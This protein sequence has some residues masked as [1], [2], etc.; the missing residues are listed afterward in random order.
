MAK[1]IPIS[2]ELYDLLAKLKR[3]DEDFTDVIMRSLK[4]TTTLADLAGRETI[5]KDKGE[6]LRSFFA[7][8][9]T[10]DFERKKRLLRK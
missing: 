2:D 1:T 4:M 7:R 10:I 5:P 8:R 3:P 6:E 9:E